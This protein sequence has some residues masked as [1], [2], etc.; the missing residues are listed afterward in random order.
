[1]NADPLGQFEREWRGPHD[2]A[3]Q[4][5]RQVIVD[6]LNGSFDA[7]FPGAR[8]EWSDPPEPLPIAGPS[9]AL[10][11]V[12]KIAPTF[13]EPED[14]GTATLSALGDVEYVED[15]IRPG[16]VVVWA[17][18]E[19]SG[20]SYTVDDELGIRVAVAG[21]SFA[22]TWPVLRTGPVLYLSE[23]HGDDDHDRETTV[24]G[25]LGL[26]RSALAGCYYRLPLMTAAGGR[27][28]LTV[29]EWCAWVT[30][31]LRDRGA[32]LLIVDTA[33]GATQVDPWG[34]AIQAVYAALRVMLAEYPALA[35]VLVVHVKKPQGRGERR[36]SDVLGEW[37]RWCDVVVMQ[38]NDGGSLD[39]AK[40][41]VRKR[42]RH[43][44]R[45]V[46]TKRGGLLVDPTEPTVGG[47]KV[48]DAACRSTFLAR[49]VWT[50]KEFGAAM[51]VTKP[52]AVKYL[53]ALDCADS[54]DVAGTR[55]WFPKETR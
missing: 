52:T 20:K 11:V 53:D 49:D 10:A 3:W 19:G 38:E 42:V 15:L 32:L 39:R 29:P 48:D 22:G 12:P 21:G 43:E 30:G 34:T 4:A 28:A 54:A 36:L 2:D 24:L 8:A 46:A 13:P 50:A 47:R 55:T 6:R 33:T 23:M 35:I 51:G 41:T 17:A 26:E 14:R 44:R 9:S 18:E 37:G 45:I 1:M 7:L 40:L 31:W 16:R 27:P 5:A 25:S